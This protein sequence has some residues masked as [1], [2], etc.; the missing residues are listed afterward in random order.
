MDLIKL[1]ITQ[2]ITAASNNLRLSSEK[3]EVVAM[4]KEFVTNSETMES[5]LKRMKKITELST[6]GIRLHRTYTFLTEEKIDFAHISEN[7][8]EHS[9]WLVN[10]LSHLLDMVNPKTFKEV[11]SKV[12]EKYKEKNEKP[13]EIEPDKEIEEISVDLSKRKHD[14]DEFDITIDDETIEKNLYIEADKEPETAAPKAKDI[15][16]KEE[17]KK[18]ASAKKEPEE[19][20]E[21][22]ILK[23][24]NILESFLEEIL[25][26]EKSLSKIDPLLK[27]LDKNVKLCLEN[28]QF[29]VSWMQKMLSDTLLLIQDK[30]Y[31][32]D[33]ELVDS[34]RACL[35]VSAAII[36]GKEVDISGYLTKAENLGLQNKKS[37]KKES[38]R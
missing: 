21:D 35:I 29:V 3:I 17:T 34:M 25:T 36:R 10:D 7:F 30:T 4:L 23:S 32:P 12:N 20:F 14:V 1:Y 16:V 15:K 5:D 22:V 8:K 13:E 28:D 27:K 2:T 9:Q 33:E 11:L 24:I 6:I 26:D 37:K 31:E 18:E 38:I 19:K